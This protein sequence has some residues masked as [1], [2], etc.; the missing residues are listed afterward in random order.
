M[1]DLYP[2]AGKE[3]SQEEINVGVGYKVVPLRPQRNML[4]L[5]WKLNNVVRF[6]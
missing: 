6:L 3:E 5:N 2:L 1:G 4:R